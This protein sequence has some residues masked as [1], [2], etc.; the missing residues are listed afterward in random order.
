[1]VYN[2]IQLFALNVPDRISLPFELYALE[3]PQHWKE[4]FN[5]L[6]QHKLGRSPVLPPIKC[7]NQYLQLLVEDLLFP[8]RFAFSPKSNSKWIY[9]KSDSVDTEYIASIVRAWARISFEDLDTNFL[10]DRDI[11]TINAMSGKDLKFKKIALSEEVWKIQNGG[12]VID[13]LYYSLIPYL[14]SSAIASA[15]LTLVNPALTED[16]IKFD[17]R[18]SISANSSS[19]EVISWAPEFIVRGK[20]K[21][22]THYYS[23][24]ATFKLDYHPGGV[25]YLN[26]DYGVRR[27]VNWELG[28]LSTG[29]TVYFNPTGS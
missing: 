4:L 21:K 18:E 28:Y 15:P 19:S 9:A 17:F 24:H 12:L 8:N 5:R 29:V 10:T 25:P 6:Q 23:Y 14:F 13:P 7:L 20:E 16:S 2:R 22:T 11:Q 1:M 3:V 26:C 27:W